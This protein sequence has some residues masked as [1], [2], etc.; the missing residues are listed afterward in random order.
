MFSKRISTLTT[1]FVLKEFPNPVLFKFVSDFYE[2]INLT[3][4]LCVFPKLKLKCNVYHLHLVCQHANI[5]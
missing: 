1:V 5:H 2:C 3:D 4:F